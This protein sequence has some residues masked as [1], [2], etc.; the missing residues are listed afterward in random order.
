MGITDNNMLSV[1]NCSLVITYI[2]HSTTNVTIITA[3]LNFTI[4]SKNRYSYHIGRNVV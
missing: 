3:S 2:Y 1:N 4:H